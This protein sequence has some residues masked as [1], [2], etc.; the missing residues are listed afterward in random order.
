MNVSVLRSVE[1]DSVNFVFSDSS[2][3]VNGV[4][5]ARY[6]RRQEEYLAVYLSSQSGCSQR[7]RMCHLTATNQLRATDAC[8][9]DYVEQADIVLDWYDKN[10][11]KA[12]KV[13]FN[14]M[15]RG[16]AFR[17]PHFLAQARELFEILGAK[18]IE[19]SLIPRFL[20]STIMP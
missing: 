5:E 15:A 3:G 7:C 19:R 10:C 13:H 2:M 16:E 6:V 12:K 1:D 14:F 4:F 18:A 17:N 9:E 11:P 20:V 8:L